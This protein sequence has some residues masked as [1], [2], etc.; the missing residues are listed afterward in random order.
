MIALPFIPSVPVYSFSTSINGASFNFDVRWNT[1]DAAWYFDVSTEEGVVLRQ[2][3]KIV[4]GAYLGRVSDSDLFTQG[5]FVARDTSGQGLDA[6]FD[7]LGT[8]VEV[9]YL[10]AL[11]IQGMLN[12]EIGA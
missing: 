7:D 2:G 4:L 12:G 6:T 8:R 10:T 11:E 1:R 9:L 5:V 3:V